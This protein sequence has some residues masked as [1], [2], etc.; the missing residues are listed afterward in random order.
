MNQ[1]V[2]LI[3]HLM[4]LRREGGGRRGRGVLRFCAAAEGDPRRPPSMKVR[5]WGG[6]G[7]RGGVDVFLLCPG[8]CTFPREAPTTATPPGFIQ[9]GPEKLE[10]VAGADRR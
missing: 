7:G 3:I 9:Q 2:Y 1:D 5:C 4:K 8:L 10:K 6:E